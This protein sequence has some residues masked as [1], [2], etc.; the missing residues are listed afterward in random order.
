MTKRRGHGRAALVA[1]V[2]I[3]GGCGERPPSPGPDLSGCTEDKDP[4]LFALAQY[5]C[6][7][8]RVYTFATISAREDW[9]RVAVGY[10]VVPE[11]EGDIWVRVK[12]EG[13][14]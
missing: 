3:L 11:A 14:A 5:E 12:R 9:K 2:L 13:A 4:E 7:D 10:G 1:L 6:G 8:K